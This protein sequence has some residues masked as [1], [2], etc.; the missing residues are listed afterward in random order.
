ML[1]SQKI[2]QT[3]RQVHNA[4]GNYVCYQERNR[5]SDLTAQGT[6]ASNQTSNH[7]YLYNSMR[8]NGLNYKF[9]DNTCGI[10]LIRTN[11][12]TNKSCIDGYALSIKVYGV[13][14]QA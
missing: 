5:S 2:R 12:K 1:T 9:G 14:V 7:L 6:T 4:Y 8:R 13:S 10:L 11:K 3:N